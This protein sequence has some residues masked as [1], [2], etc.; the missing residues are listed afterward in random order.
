MIPQLATSLDHDILADIYKDNIN[1]TIWQRTL[2]SQLK[3][4]INNLL[5]QNYKLNTSISVKPKNAF[6]SMQNEFC[7]IENTDC[8][9]KDIAKLVDMFS[10]LFELKR[11]GLRLAVLD[12]PMCPRFHVDRVPC[13]LV[14]TYQGKQLN[15]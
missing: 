10:F 7:H 13:R 1:I 2:S 14:I 4:A 3:K 5:A 9:S 6:Q 15:G 12:R 11:V 8:L